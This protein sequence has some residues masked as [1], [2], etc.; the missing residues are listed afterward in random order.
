MSVVLGK[1]LDPFSADRIKDLIESKFMPPP[2]K[3]PGSPYDY[4]PFNEH[5][6]RVIARKEL[7]N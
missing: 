7:Q 2:T 4:A 1:D 6:L 3:L 5:L